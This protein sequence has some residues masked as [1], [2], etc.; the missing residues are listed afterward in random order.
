MYTSH[1]VNLEVKDHHEYIQFVH[2][3]LRKFRD[4]THH[5]YT[6]LCLKHLEN[7]KTGVNSA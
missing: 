4:T 5:V 3:A 1:V 7:L 2:E 6:Q